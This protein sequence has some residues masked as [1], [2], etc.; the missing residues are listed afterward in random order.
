MKRG[1]STIQPISSWFPCSS[2]AVPPSMR[3]EALS[4]HSALATGSV[5]T[6]DEAWPC[7]HATSDTLRVHVV[8]GPRH[9]HPVFETPLLTSQQRVGTTYR[10]ERIIVSRLEELESCDLNTSR[11]IVVDS[12]LLREEPD[13]FRHSVRQTSGTDWL[14]AGDETA[15]V[16][17]NPLNLEFARG[18]IPW[19]CSQ[20]QLVAA[21]DAVSSGKLWFPRAVIEG[22]YLLLVAGRESKQ[23]TEGERRCAPC[24][25]TARETEVLGL[26]RRGMTNRQ[27]ADRLSISANTVKKHI[28]NVL[29]KRGLHGRRQAIV[30]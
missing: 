26:M 1:Q 9:N 10:V 11:V 12:N 24:V 15:A 14:V 27:I 3:S 22:L 25:L 30:S 28:A 18:F 2:P 19:T 6:I 16:Q 21:L 23:I 20:P 17:I 4:T 13:V 5:P 8:R 29:E 7:V